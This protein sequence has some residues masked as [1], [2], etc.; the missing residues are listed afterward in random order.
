MESNMHSCR[1]LA[2]VLLAV[3]TV[4]LAADEK[5]FL[6]RW[7]LMSTGD[8]PGSYW[9]E[10]KDEGGKLTAKFL[11]RGGHPTAA[12][13]V[14]VEGDELIFS[15]G[16]ANQP[17]SEFRGKVAGNKLTA[18]LKRA[19][20]T[21]TLSGGRPPSWPPAN[22][23]G[24]HT[25]GAPVVLFDGKALD[26]FGVQNPKVPMNWSIEDGVMTN[27][28]HANNLVSK[29]KFKDFKINAEYKV[30]PGTN[31]GIYLR[32]R[33]EL[34]VLDEFGKPPFERG[35]MAIYGWKAPAVNASKPV[36]EWQTME[37]IVVGNRVTVTHNDQRVHDNAVL[38]AITGG[39]LDTDEMAPGPIMIQ[40][41]HSK[42][43]FRKITVTPIT[44][45]AR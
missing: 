38:E 26:A 30:G 10:V 21:V 4:T 11:N 16:A 39:A 33:Y 18:T 34:Q 43:W 12:E 9:L 27:G 15:H 2:A 24:N 44:R 36:G 8:T 7:T 6:G 13:N 45:A 14:R 31:S 20:R 41:D 32:G 37:A 17:Q 22:A 35:H 25:Y 42:I 1:S 40:G 29:E 28:E 5:A 19:D 23:N 3:L